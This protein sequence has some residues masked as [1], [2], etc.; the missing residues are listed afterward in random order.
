MEQTQAGKI[1]SSVQEIPGRGETFQAARE[2]L[3]ET[4]AGVGEQ[5]K[6]AAQYANEA[7][8][9]KPW[10]SIG[11]GF[12]IGVVVGALIAIAAGSRSSSFG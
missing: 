6:H 12:G 1:P 3:N 4:L 8:H 11:I 7:V 5:A 2:R 9:H 10:T